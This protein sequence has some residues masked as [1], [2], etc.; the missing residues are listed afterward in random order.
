MAVGECHVGECHARTGPRRGATG[1]GTP[2]CRKTGKSHEKAGRGPLQRQRD[3]GLGRL[4]SETVRQF[5][6]TALGHPVSG[7][8]LR[9]PSQPGSAPHCGGPAC[10][11]RDPQLLSGTDGGDRPG[12]GPERV[13]GA[14]RDHWEGSRGLI[15][16]KGKV[17]VMWAVADGVQDGATHWAQSHPPS[18]ACPWVGNPGE[19]A[20][21]HCHGAL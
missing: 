9:L 2:D 20:C 10:T 8:W 19:A 6:S 17:T 1:Q 15:W 16:H 11:H 14:A 4:A 21:G 3:L 13:P 5:I 18:P 7:S 12:Q